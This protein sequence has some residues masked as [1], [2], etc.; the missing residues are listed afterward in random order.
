MGPLIQVQGEDE[1]HGTN[2]LEQ[3]VVGKCLDYRDFTE[4]QFQ[5]WVSNCWRLRDPI[6][7]PKSKRKIFF[8]Y[9]KE[10]RDRDVLLYKGCACFQSAFISFHPISSEIAMK[11]HN[12]DKTSI[13]VT[14][15][16]IPL[17]YNRLEVVKKALSKFAT[18]I[19]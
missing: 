5:N 9:W 8:F 19:H 6:R 7:V 17:K 10:A 1:V 16:G 13:W 4:N 3:D 15:E 12:F 18:V 2:N 14:D 11:I